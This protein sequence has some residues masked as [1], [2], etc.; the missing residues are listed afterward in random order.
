MDGG[1][2][3]SS[4]SGSKWYPLAQS[5]RTGPRKCL[6]GRGNVKTLARN[7]DLFLFLERSLGRGSPTWIFHLK[8][9]LNWQIFTTET[10]RDL[11]FWKC[12]IGIYVL[13]HG[14]RFEFD[15]LHIKMRKHKMWWWKTAFEISSGKVAVMQNLTSYNSISSSAQKPARLLSFGRISEGLDEA[16]TK[17]IP[18]YLWASF[19]EQSI[20]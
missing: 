4:F 15:F 19:R 11:A 10:E 2:K 17:S 1:S 6:K 18:I 14:R 7:T 8:N 5:A 20:N 16:F 9:A 3:T 12:N 13:P